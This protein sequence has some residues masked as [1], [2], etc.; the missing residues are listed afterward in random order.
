MHASSKILILIPTY[1]E[2]DN[3]GIV[4]SSI[5]NLGLDSDLLFVDDNSPDGTGALLARKAIE[6]P[7]IHVLHRPGKLGV[8]SAH[9]D[10][11]RWSYDNGYNILITMDSDLTH[12]PEE[13]PRFLAQ[14]DV[15]DVVVGS[16]FTDRHSLPGWIW[17]RKWMTHTGHFLTSRLLGLPYDATG[18][19]RLYR[20]SRIPRGIFDMVQHPGYGFFFESLHR[21]HFNGV[22]I[23]EVPIVLPARAYGRSKVRLKDILSGIQ[24][25]MKLAVQTRFASGALRYHAPFAPVTGHVPSTEETAWNDYWMPQSHRGKWLYDLIAIFYRRFIIRPLVNRFLGATFERN[26][27][28]LHAGCGSGLVDIDMARQLR[29]DALDISAQ[30]LTEYARH[31][32]GDVTLIHGSIFAIPSPPQYY[33]GLFNL[34]VME[35]F[36]EDQIVPILRE[37]N[38]VIK[39]GACIVLFWP[40]AYGLT[41]RVLKGV[42]W[43]LHR[44][45]D[46][47]IQLHPPELTHIVSREQTGRWLDQSGFALREFYFGVHDLFTYQV[48]VAEKIIHRDVPE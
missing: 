40:P 16:R 28:V 26:A 24:N 36:P 17:W 8:G 34:G 11:I 41:V 44:V 5:K 43:M 29:I 38:R 35:H 45:F 20:L 12:S 10:G 2:A 47:K 4:I 21:L 3:I 23:R 42:H 31:H 15:T 7:T 48:I 9:R 25:L 22:S 27:R 14:S 6:D 37:F 33:D 30:A 13:I 46:D 19:F 39:P 18:A 1:N 32:S